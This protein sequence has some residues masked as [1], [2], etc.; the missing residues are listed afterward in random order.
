M[1]PRIPARSAI[2]LALTTCLTLC[3]AH[4]TPVRQVLVRPSSSITFGV[5]SPNPSLTMNGS[6]REFSGAIS[7]D[8]EAITESNIDL[9]LTLSSAQLPPEQILQAVFI[10]TA[11]AR[12]PQKSSSFRSSGIE[13][14]KDNS[15]L[16]HGTYTWMNKRKP[17]SVPVEI[18]KATPS[19]TEI[20]VL[21]DGSFTAQ[22]VPG[23][24]SDVATSA[25]G[26]RGWSKAIL[27]FSPAGRS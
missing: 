21:M 24:L 23:E 5:K 26:S 4:A 11:L 15:Y 25:R 3:S 7:L 27:V 10:Q 14:L 9:S 13:H 16:I 22:G 20:R 6:F 2:A 17:A 8:T 18:V 19:M 1:V 12:F